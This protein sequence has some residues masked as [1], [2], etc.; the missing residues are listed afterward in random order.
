MKLN[1]DICEVNVLPALY[2]D[3]LKFLFL[4]FVVKCVKKRN[5]YQTS[6]IFFVL[7]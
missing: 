3:Y 4:A 2:T 1:L 7:M 5:F 6:Q